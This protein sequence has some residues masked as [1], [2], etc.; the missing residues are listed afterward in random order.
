MVCME[1][2]QLSFEEKKPQQG[3]S[4]AELT[5]PVFSRNET[6]FRSV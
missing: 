6:T 4:Q 2:D 3:Q 1:V 5:S